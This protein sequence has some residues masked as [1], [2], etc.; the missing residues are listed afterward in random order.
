MTGDVSM[1]WEDARIFLAVARQGQILGA[2]RGLALDAATVGRRLNNLEKALQKR[3]LD[4]TTRGVE[5]TPD[6]EALF[7]A[8]QRVENELFRVQS[9]LSSDLPLAGT[10][11][12]GAPDGFGVSFLA[13]R[14]GELADLYPALRV[15]LVPLPRSFSLSRREADLAIMVG[16]PEKGRLVARKLC[17]YT[18]SLYA[19]KDYL[20]RCDVPRCVAD[21][22][23]HRLVGY[24]EDLLYAESLNY[25]RD[26]SRR[27]QSNIDIASATGQMQAVL[28]G[29]G[30]GI[31]HDYLAQDMA[32]LVPVL[33]QMCVTRAYWIAWHESLGDEPRVKAAKAFIEQC[34]ANSPLPFSRQT[35]D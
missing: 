25:G 9:E 21:L 4:R 17:D 7:A 35:G 32:D 31:L 28:G 16:R 18:L 29:A 11:R 30:I 15:E 23:K 22:E 20:E 24:V 26:F 27:W 19:S 10:V 6:G 3:L 2:A 5:L 13:P 14:L 34:V 33:E 12:I 1:N 8:L